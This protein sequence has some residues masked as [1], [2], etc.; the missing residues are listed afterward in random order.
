[1]IHRKESTFLKPASFSEKVRQYF[2]R[3]QHK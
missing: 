3:P 2:H 1:L